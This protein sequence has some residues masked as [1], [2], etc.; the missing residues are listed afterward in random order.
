MV[1]L[2]SYQ[3]AC[4]DYFESA[5]KNTVFCLPTGTG[6]TVTMVSM[7]ARNYHKYPKILIVCPT[8]FIKSQILETFK[9]LGQGNLLNNQ[10]TVSVFRTAA[11]RKYRADLV[12]FDEC[13]RIACASNQSILENNPR[14]IGFTATPVRLDGLPLSPLD[15]IF[16][17][18]PIGW[19]MKE[20]HLCNN[21]IEVTAPYPKFSRESDF[22]EQWTSYNNRKHFS[23]ILESYKKHT[24]RGA[25]SIVF[26]T[27]LEH[28]ERLKLTYST[29]RIKA[30]TIS[31]QDS[32]SVKDAKMKAFKSG[33]IDMLI[34]VFL[35]SEGADIPDCDTVIFCAFTNSVKEYYQRVGRVLR[36]KSKAL[37][38]DHAGMIAHHLSVR[39]NPGW[40]HEFYEA[41][42]RSERNK[43]KRQHIFLCPDCSEPL[44]NLTI[45]KC[46]NCGFEL[47][48]DI[49][50]T[51]RLDRVPQIIKKDLVIYDRQPFDEFLIRL[52]KAKSVSTKLS[53]ISRAYPSM[54]T[55]ENDEILI[56]FMARFT[57]PSKVIEILKRL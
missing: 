27:T 3:H 44:P 9:A 56:E 49:I 50:S 33:L 13:H 57:T 20:G 39:H 17:P 32:D 12:I 23:D 22:D 6:K 45:K 52:K 54:R 51:H 28:C 30:E 53:L 21:I 35:V 31:Y 48:P 36:P 11:I 16:E 34:N 40:S 19:Y 8:R 10:V 37:I 18:Y 5:P 26:G 24:W 1:N 29:L 47:N 46:P 25:K 2:R 4:I 42:T 14:V 15:D 43:E 55:E 41:L 7:I 38:I